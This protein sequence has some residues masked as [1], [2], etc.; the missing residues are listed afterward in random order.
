MFRHWRRFGV[1]ISRRE[2]AFL[3]KHEGARSIAHFYLDTRMSD[4]HCDER[5]TEAGVHIT[6]LL[7]IL[8][9]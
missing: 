2:R 7:E 3:K 9:R 6:A 1:S 4:G 8:T 5:K